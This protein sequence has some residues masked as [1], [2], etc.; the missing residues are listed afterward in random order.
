MGG[1]RFPSTP[2]SAVL[3]VSSSDTV[4]RGRAFSQ[5]VRA[6]WRPVYK[7]VHL[8]WRKTAEEAK[9]LTQGFFLHALEKG[10]FVS[11]EPTR[12]KFRTYVKRCLDNYVASAEASR[13]TLKRGG[14]ALSLPFEEVDRELTAAST[15]E[16]DLDQLFDR[17]W[18]RS[19]LASCTA[20]LRDELARRGREKA[21][22]V[23]IRYDLASEPDERPTYAELAREFDIKTSDVS[24]YLNATRRRFREIVLQRLEELTVTREEF[25]EEVCALLGPSALD[26][27]PPPGA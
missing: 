21:C 20:T 9:D 15:T 23:F 25:E 16:E 17:E 14:L 19:L 13:T 11:Y 12:A 8:R 26:S 1:H 2:R 5:L 4:A 27:N 3:G 24:N 7:H 22:E 10:V 6:Y 18:I